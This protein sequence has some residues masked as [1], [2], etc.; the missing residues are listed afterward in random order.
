VGI[1]ILLM[2]SSTLVPVYHIGRLYASISSLNHA[3]YTLRLLHYFYVCDVI[4]VK[5]SYITFSNSWRTVCTGIRVH[6][7]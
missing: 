1:E 7:L 5:S 2:S 6:A 3:H 4:F